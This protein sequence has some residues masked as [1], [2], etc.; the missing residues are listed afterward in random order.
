MKYRYEY[1]PFREP[2]INSKSKKVLDPN[3]QVTAY[4]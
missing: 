1:P 2:N 3:F 4:P